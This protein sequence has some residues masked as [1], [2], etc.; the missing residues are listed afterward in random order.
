MSKPSIE[1]LLPK[2]REELSSNTIHIEARACF[3]KNE[4]PLPPKLFANGIWAGQPS[5]TVDEPQ[6]EVPN[7]QFV[8]YVWNAV[9]LPADPYVQVK[10][11]I[12]S[13]K[14]TFT[15]SD[16]KMAIRQNVAPPPRPKLYLVLLGTDYTDIRNAFPELPGVTNTIEK[17]RDTVQ[18]TSGLMYDI[19]FFS[20]INDKATLANWRTFV[21]DFTASRKAAIHPDDMFVIYI[22]GH[23]SLD[24]KTG[25]YYYAMFETKYDK[26]CKYDFAEAFGFDELIPLAILPCRRVVIFETCQFSSHELEDPLRDYRRLEEEQFL[27]LLAAEPGKSAIWTDSNSI[28]RFSKFLLEGWNGSADGFDPIKRTVVDSDKD[29]KVTIMENYSFLTERLRRLNQSS[30]ERQM[31]EVFGKDLLRYIDIPLSEH[32]C[33][34]ETRGIRTIVGPRKPLGDI[35]EL[36]AQ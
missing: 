5:K 17:V 11:S 23:G 35:A 13:A 34:E 14:R 9:R 32:D 25:R 31:A 12:E 28:G 4:T 24:P 10:V 3:P 15:A 1:I 22:A 19:E 21:K 33:P 20:F 26:Y 16:S 18:N 29:G 27:L 7:L 6:S 30:R 2:T 8:R 36:S